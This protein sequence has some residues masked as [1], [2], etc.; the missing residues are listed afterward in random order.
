LFCP[1]VLISVFF[2]GRK[3]SLESFNI[4]WTSKNKKAFFWCWCCFF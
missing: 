3:G 4:N 1:T 2:I